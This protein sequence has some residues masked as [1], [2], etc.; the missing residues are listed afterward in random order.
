ML[1]LG[2]PLPAFRLP[3]A[4][5]RTVDSGSLDRAPGL[6]VMFICNHC[7]FVRHLR[8]GLVALARDYRPRGLGMVAISSNDIAEYPEDAPG[9]MREEGYPFPYLFDETQEVAKAFRAACT[10]DF[11]LFAPAGGLVYRGR[12]DESRPDNGV[13]VTGRDLRT[14]IDALLSGRPV[15]TEGQLPS[16]GCNIKWRKGNEPDYFPRSPTQ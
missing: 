1:P 9:K 5:G 10:P 12:F 4:T 2:T 8:E 6:L 3:D 15:G 14:R 11:F 13:E 7:P 16:V